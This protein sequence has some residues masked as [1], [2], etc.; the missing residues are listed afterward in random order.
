MRQ[1]N[2]IASAQ[3][4]EIVS[5]Q[6]LAVQ[7]QEKGSLPTIAHYLAVLGEAYLLAALNKYSER[8]VRR[9]AAPPKLVPLSNA[10]L[11]AYTDLVPPTAVSDPRR[12]GHWLENACLAATVNAG[13]QVAY[14]REEPYEVDMIVTGRG[15]QWA[16][17]VKS[18]GYSSLDLRGLL[19]F[20]ERYPA[21]RPLV[22]GEAAF[23]DIAERMGIDFIRW[24]DYLL[25]GLP[26]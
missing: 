15:S 11:T 16:V 26:A 17:E 23:G 1:I 9:R 12:W 8:E 5:L 3:P 13:Y 20:I 7:L 10:F 22:I 14:W 19:A 24:Q 6:K 4:S 21:F 18:G 25:H 2:S